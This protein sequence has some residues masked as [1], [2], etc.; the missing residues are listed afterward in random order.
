MK[1]EEQIDDICIMGV[2]FKKTMIKKFYLYA[3]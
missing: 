1:N 3:V 2:R